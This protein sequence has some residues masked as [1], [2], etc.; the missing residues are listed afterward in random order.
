MGRN[1]SKAA[2]CKQQWYKWGQWS[3]QMCTNRAPSRPRIL[4]LP[5]QGGYV[6]GQRIIHLQTTHPRLEACSDMAGC[7][8]DQGISNSCPARLPPLT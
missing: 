8:R 6:E 2:T 3:I 7:G 5:H 4:H 1:E